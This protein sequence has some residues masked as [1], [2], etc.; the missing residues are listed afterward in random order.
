MTSGVVSSFNFSCLAATNS[1]PDPPVGEASP[2]RITDESRKIVNDGIY[3]GLLAGSEC[4]RDNPLLELPLRK[5][6]ESSFGL[7]DRSDFGKWFRPIEERKR[8]ARLH[9]GNHLREVLAERFG[10]NSLHIHD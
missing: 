5:R 3:L 6:A 4:I 7:Y 10:R 9:S 1:F 2:D 8:L